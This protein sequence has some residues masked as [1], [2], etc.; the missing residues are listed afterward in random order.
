MRNHGIL[1]AG[2]AVAL[3]SVGACVSAAQEITLYSFKG[4]NSSDGSAPECNLIF[5][6]AGNL[7]GTT[8]EGG[9]YGYG[10][11]FKLTPGGT[12]TVLYSFTG[13]NDGAYPAASLIMD[14]SGN[15]YG[16]TEEGGA[17]GLGVV[18]KVPPGGGL[19]TVLHSFGGSDGA[20]PTANVV[21]DASGNLYGTTEAGGA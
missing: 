13:G 7:Y 1:T 17:S 18:F 21:M 20:Y 14:P 11:V 12:E 2:I 10:V 4:S 15:L 9:A 3:L 16:T 8:E 6:S 5:D 19:E